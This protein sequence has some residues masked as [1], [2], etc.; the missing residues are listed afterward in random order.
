MIKLIILKT[1]RDEIL[2]T[3]KKE[4]LKIYSLLREMETNPHKAKVLGHVG[5]ISIREIKY[6]NFRF[7]FILDGHK[8]YLFS[9]G[10]VEEL[11]I[12]FIKMSKKNNQQ[13]TIDEI[14]QMLKLIEEDS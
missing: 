1:L 2:K 12:Q 3:F 9:K 13:K 8:L 14:K 10:L 7:Y 5:N 11:L 4:S 6:K